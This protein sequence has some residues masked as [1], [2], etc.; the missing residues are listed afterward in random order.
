MATRKA[1]GVLYALLNDPNPM[2]R[3]YAYEGLEEMGLLET[4]LV[5][6]K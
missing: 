2:V 3:I 1:A 6:L 5:T 4:I